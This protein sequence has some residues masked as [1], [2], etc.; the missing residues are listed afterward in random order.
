MCA[1]L[2]AEL[3]LDQP[4]QGT[5][6]QDEAERPGDEALAGLQEVRTG[7]VGRAAHG[8]QQTVL[9]H[10]A[11]GCHIR[12]ARVFETDAD[13]AI[14]IRWRQCGELGLRTRFAL[15]ELEHDVALGIQ[16]AESVF[17]AGIH[18]AQI[19][20]Q[21]VAADECQCRA[22]AP[23]VARVQRA[24]HGKEAAPVV[25]PRW[26]MKDRTGA[27]VGT[28]VVLRRGRQWWQVRHAPAAG[29]LAHDTVVCIPEQYS[30]DALALRKGTGGE[31]REVL[32]RSVRDGYRVE[33]E[34]VQQIVGL[35][36]AVAEEFA[37]GQC[38]CGQFGVLCLLLA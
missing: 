2:P 27:G 18:L 34:Q 11:D 1:L 15:G 10:R 23:A 38:M 25:S 35:T 3:M 24:L 37:V 28:R 31:R 16:Q 17:R 36:Q 9:A 12:L 33:I 6:Q 30:G 29:Y 13:R 5:E 7:N 20:D 32:D 8:E 14:R 19:G 22:Q 21:R 26:R 4:G